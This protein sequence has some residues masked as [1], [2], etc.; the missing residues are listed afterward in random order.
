MELEKVVRRM[1]KSSAEGIDVDLINIKILGFADNLI[2]LGKDIESVKRS[3][4]S[5]DTEF[6]SKGE[7]NKTYGIYGK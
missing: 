7:R 4:K 1:Q 2:I 5:K 3:T 6:E